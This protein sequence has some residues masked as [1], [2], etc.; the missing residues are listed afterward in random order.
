MEPGQKHERLHH[1]KEAQCSLEALRELPR[2]ERR[3]VLT[4]KVDN[5]R[6]QCSSYRIVRRAVCQLYCFMR[7]L[8]RTRSGSG[9]L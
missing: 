7:G 9:R 6:S 4:A 3:V 2:P 1:S 5:I 8:P